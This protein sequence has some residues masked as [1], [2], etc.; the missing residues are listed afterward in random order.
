[1][2]VLSVFKEL[3]LLFF[4]T[5]C[6]AASSTVDMIEEFL[7]YIWYSCC[8][9][10]LLLIQKDYNAGSSLYYEVVF[11]YTGS[12]FRRYVEKPKDQDL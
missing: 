9:D 3:V 11:I 5:Y 6:T 10:T 2:F 8:F 7:I 4:L 12:K 1:M